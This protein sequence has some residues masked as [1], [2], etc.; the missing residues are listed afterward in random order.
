MKQLIMRKLKQWR[1]TL[2]QSFRLIVARKRGTEQCPLLLGEAL[3]MA[4]TG[5]WSG[6]ER[7]LNATQ[8]CFADRLRKDYPILSEDDLHVI[9]L[10][11]I[12]KEHAE[13]ARFL[14]I[15][16]ESFRMRR[17]RLKKKMGVCCE[18]ISDYLR[19]LYT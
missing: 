10:I 16:L 11:R 3:Q 1:E 13:I 9:Y 14:N 12:G 7:H 19:G 8:C 2:I 17:C 18:S 15:K 5:D 6:M 4:G